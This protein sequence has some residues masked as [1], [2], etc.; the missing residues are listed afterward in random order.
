MIV[1]KLRNCFVNLGSDLT[2]IQMWITPEQRT[3]L[4]ARKA[5]F[6]GAPFN[7]ILLQTIHTHI[8]SFLWRCNVKYYINSS[9]A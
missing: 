2:S 4:R 7:Y 3:N 1:D 6:R 9:S 8:I 5:G